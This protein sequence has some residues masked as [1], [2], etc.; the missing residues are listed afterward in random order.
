M[1]LYLDTSALVKAHV[2]EQHCGTVRRWIESATVVATSVVAYPEAA[3]A[4]ARKNREG[5]I[6][7]DALDRVL[8]ALERDWADCAV[9]EVQE[10]AAGALAVQHALRGFDAVHLSAALALQAEA[11]KGTVAF[12]AFDD[13]LTRAAIAEGLATLEPQQ[14]RHRENESLR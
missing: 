5:G 13:K 10:K 12:C 1:I 14:D 8:A 7:K 4:F 11:P 3:A 2:E 6:G 9:L